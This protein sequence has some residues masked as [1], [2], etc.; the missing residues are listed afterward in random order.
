NAYE[1][2]A[3]PAVPKSLYKAIRLLES[4]RAAREIF[5]DEVFEHYLR[6][7]RAEQAAFD[8]SVTSW[9]RERNFERI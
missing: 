2:A 6:T 4:S 9:E 1:S 3:V 5:G 7:A 8:R